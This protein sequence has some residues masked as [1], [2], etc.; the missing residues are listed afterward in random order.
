MAGVS[1]EGYDVSDGMTEVSWDPQ[2]FATAAGNSNDIVNLNVDATVSGATITTDY[3]GGKALGGWAISVMMGDDAVDG[4]AEKLD[5]DGNAAL[6]TT[7]AKDD[8]PATFSFAVAG[9]QD[10]KL[11]GGENYEAQAVEYEHTGLALAGTMDAGT[12]EVAYTTQT[13]KVYVHHEKDQVMGYTGNLLGGDERDDGKVSVGIRYIDGGGR[14]RTFVS[15]D[16]IKTPKDNGSKGVWTF[17]NVPADENVIAEARKATDDTNIKLLDPDELAAYTGMDVN[18]ITGGAFGAMG[19]FNHTVELCPLQ[20]TTPQD[21]GECASFAYVTTHTVSGLVW[22]KGVVRKGD[23]FEEKAAVFVPGLTV[24]LS[25][26][27]GKNLAGDEES[28]TTAEK[29][30]RKDKTKGLDATHEFSFSSVAAGAYRL[31]VPSGWRAKQG[32]MGSETAV[33]AAL[34]PLAD[35]LSLDIT[36]ATATVYGRVDGSDGFPLDSVT[37]TVNGRSG[38]TD[39]HGRYIVD[40]ISAVRGKVF[41]SASRAGYNVAK[42]DSTSVEF[43]ANS[44]TEHDIDLAGVQ[45]RATFSGKVIA[46]T[47]GAPIAGVEIK[48]DNAAPLNAATSGA[49]KGKLVTG[50]DGTFMAEAAAK[51]LG[52]IANVSA[53]KAGWT[54]VPSVYPA[55]AHPGATTTTITFSGFVNAT[56]M[57]KVAA[58]G[59]GPLSGV[60]VSATP[61]AGGD[62]ADADTTGV[63]GSFSLSVSGVGGSYTLTATLANH[64]FEIPAQYRTAVNVA[65]GQTVN[66]G[67][68]QAMTFAAGGVGAARVRATDDENTA[69]TDES[70]PSRYTGTVRVAWKAGT[71]PDGHVVT[72]QAQTK[73][74]D[75]AWTDFGTAV[76]S[77]ALAADPATD[78]TARTETAPTESDGGFMVRV[79]STSDNGTSGDTTDDPDAINSAAVEV[80]AVDPSASGVK[81]RRQAAADSDE[82]AAGGDFI[83]AS[84]TA[85]TS[86]NSDFRVV[87]QVTP[88]LWVERAVCGWSWR[89]RLP[90]PARKESLSP[91]RSTTRTPRPWLWLCPAGRLRR[92]PSPQ[93]TSERPSRSPSS[94]CRVPRMPRK[95]ARSGSAPRKLI[96]LRGPAA[97]N[98][99]T[100]SAWLTRHQPG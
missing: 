96:S 61:V 13:L 86:D 49:N 53:S 37:V 90:A 26:V 99:P 20:A 95:T 24:S 81:A 36:P 57:G 68:I 54:F 5:D 89:V 67:T 71:V 56:I 27:E 14:S 70:M 48:V 18:G 76:T 8:L 11:D 7:V 23:D 91:R 62:A 10:D 80:A 29:D 22:K 60:I 46:S 31:G 63:T 50:A 82:A 47:G 43:A 17:S 87:A 98:P 85:V 77:D 79:V 94:R 4:S 58:P 55:A 1:A 16:S 74:G 100:P 59:G 72:Y 51:K 83:Q 97:N 66:I 64:T 93:P 88:P 84:W 6:M 39:D 42:A 75:G 65:P 28:Y 78:S 40:G 25:P 35:D 12:I 92:S 52:D 33:G 45:A 15:A 2:M 3:G 73:V 21:H 32:D 38:M 44:V 9:D 41:V 30:T 19:G 69:D 34:N